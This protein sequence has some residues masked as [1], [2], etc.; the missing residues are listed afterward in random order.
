MRQ[1]MQKG[2]D[3]RHDRLRRLEKIS[4]GQQ[5]SLARLLALPEH[6]LG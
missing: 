1:R 6:E 2:R 3:S 4:A 5:V